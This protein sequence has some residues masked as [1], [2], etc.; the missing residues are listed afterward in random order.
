MILSS[1]TT[2]KVTA[3]V[4]SLYWANL[5]LSVVHSNVKEWW[6]RN[7]PKIKG[8][9]NPSHTTN[10][11]VKL[12]DPILK[13]IMMDP[14]TP[15][16]CPFAVLMFTLLSKIL[17]NNPSAE[18]VSYLKQLTCAPVSNK[19][20][21]TRSFTFILKVIPFVFPCWMNITSFSALVVQFSGSYPFTSHPDEFPDFLVFS[22]LARIYA[23]LTIWSLEMPKA[24]TNSPSVI[25]L[26]SVS[27]LPL[28]FNS[29][30]FSLT[31]R[32]S[33]LKNELLNLVGTKCDD[34]CVNVI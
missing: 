2:C 22:S 29:S 32:L 18:T 8:L 21:N 16:L 24:S 5:L 14:F 6:L 20:A 33:C 26:T 23:A 11:W 9:F 27:T 13:F 25:S 31:A 28:F 3:M 1:I 10:L 15:I 7:S 30:F 17:C 4:L 19:E 12:Q 34:S